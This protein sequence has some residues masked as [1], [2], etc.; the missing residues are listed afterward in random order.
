M[1]EAFNPKRITTLEGWYS[2]PEKKSV[3]DKVAKKISQFPEGKIRDMLLQRVSIGK[4]IR[5]FL[6]LTMNEGEID[7]ETLSSIGSAIE[8]TH[9]ATLIFDDTIDEH[10][11]REGGRKGIHTILGDSATESAGI[12]DHLAEYFFSLGEQ[13]IFELNLSNAKK[14]QIMAQFTEMKQRM[15]VAQLADKLILEKPPQ[16]SW[17]EWCLS[18]SYQKTSGLM[19]YPFAITGIVQDFNSLE[20]Q[21]KLKECGNALGK[22]YQ[23]YDD[24]EDIRVEIQAGPILVFIIT[25]SFP[26][27]SKPFSCF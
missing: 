23:L 9:Q 6:F 11:T 1:N 22:I 21:S 17:T 24:L 18:Q 16:M 20:Q 14:L 26:L 10:S 5:P 27:V 12:A 15:I 8:L 4:R 13:S 3:E 2:S 25:F 19:A 7:K